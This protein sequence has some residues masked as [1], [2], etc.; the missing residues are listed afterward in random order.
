MPSRMGIGCDWRPITDL[1]KMKFLQ[2]RKEAEA[3]KKVLLE[4]GQMDS[5]GQHRCVLCGAKFVTGRQLG[6]HMSRKHPS[7]TGDYG[8]KK[9]LK[10]VKQVERKRRNYFKDKRKRAHRQREE[11]DSGEES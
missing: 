2:L 5:N 4:K 10:S 8:V 9:Q 7:T 3:I 11:G 1:D 6:G